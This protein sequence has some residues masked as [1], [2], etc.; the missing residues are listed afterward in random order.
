MSITSI[1]LNGS[2]ERKEEIEKRQAAEKEHLDKFKKRIEEKFQTYFDD[3]RNINLKFE[4][5]DHI[6]RSIMY[7]RCCFSLLLFF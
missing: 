5:M 7:G 2:T 6:Y 4:P 3:P 1:C